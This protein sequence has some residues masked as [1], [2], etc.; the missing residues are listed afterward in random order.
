MVSIGYFGIIVAEKDFWQGYFLPGGLETLAKKQLEIFRRDIANTYLPPSVSIESLEGLSK[1]D[2]A[3]AGAITSAL[4]FCALKKDEPKLAALSA[5]LHLLTGFKHFVI[6]A[7]DEKSGTRTK[8]INLPYAQ[9]AEDV[10]KVL[11][12]HPEVITAKARLMSQLIKHGPRK[13]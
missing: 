3:M 11:N 5:T 1:E 8:I 2:D 4:V 12:D 7:Q 10:K 13:Y 6:I 9:S